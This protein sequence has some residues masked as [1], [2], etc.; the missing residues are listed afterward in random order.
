[1]DTDQRYL[2]ADAGENR[3]D[4][5]TAVTAVLVG[6]RLVVAHVGDSRAVLLRAGQGAPALLLLCIV[7]AWARA[8][9]GGERGRVREQRAAGRRAAQQWRCQ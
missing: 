5:C 2:Q 7:C 4:G 9:R 8:C 6:Q 3:D 1:M